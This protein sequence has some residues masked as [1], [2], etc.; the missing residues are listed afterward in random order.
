MLIH[1]HFILVYFITLFV[2]IT[3]NDSLRCMFFADGRIDVGVLF[4]SDVTSVRKKVTSG[5]KSTIYENYHGSLA[6]ISNY[7]E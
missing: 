2:K 1:D 7:F 5:K 6:E 4:H 3:K